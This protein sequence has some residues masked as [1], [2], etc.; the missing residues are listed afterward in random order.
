MK[1]LEIKKGE[2]FACCL[3]KRPHY[4]FAGEGEAVVCS[5]GVNDPEHKELGY[6]MLMDDVSLSECQSN[7][8]LIADAGNAAQKCGLFP[9]ELLKQRN[10]L[11]D[12]LADLVILY[13]CDQKG[14]LSGQPTP[15]QWLGTI[16]MATAIIES[17]KG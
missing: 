4:V 13:N 1:G 7:A 14:L 11:R 16:E 3:E 5:M 12:V 2:W 8:R 15:E 9:S 6:E 10:E 17:I